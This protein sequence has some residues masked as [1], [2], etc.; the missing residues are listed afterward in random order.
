MEAIR[1][2]KENNNK[3]TSMI[4]KR[5]KKSSKKILLIFLGSNIIPITFGLTM[6]NFEGINGKRTKT[7]GIKMVA[8]FSIG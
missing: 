5:I 4:I 1:V 3:I 6:I 8:I 7:T 2:E